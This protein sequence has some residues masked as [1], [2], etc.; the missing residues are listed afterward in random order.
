MRPDSGQHRPLFVKRFYNKRAA[1][2]D[3]NHRYT[4][5][6]GPFNQMIQAGWALEGLVM[7]SSQ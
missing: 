5:T 4:V 2:L 6:D 7:C 3:S 1:Q